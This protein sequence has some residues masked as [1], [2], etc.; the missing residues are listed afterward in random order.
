MKIAYF[1]CFSGISGNM[2]LGALIDA[3]LNLNEL[4]KQLK[5]LRLT[6]YR[7]QLKKTKKNGISAAY[8]DV[9]GGKDQPHRNLDDIKRII[10]GSKLSKE[11]KKRSVGIFTRLA[12]A[13]AKVHGTNTDNIHF[14]EVG[15]IDAIIDIVGCA[16]ALEMMGIREV[17]SS[18]LPLSRGFVKTSHGKLPVPAPATIELL[19]GIPVYDTGIKGELVTPTGAAVITSIASSFGLLPAMDIGAVGYGAGK[20][21]YGHPNVLRVMIG[22][23]ARQPGKETVFLIETNIDDMNPQFYDH[24]IERLL[25]AKALDVWLENIQMK[26]NRPGIKLSVLLNKKDLDPISRIILSETT[27]L[28]FRIREVARMTVERKFKTIKTK[29]GNIRVKVSS[30]KDFPKKTSPEYEDCKKA[31]KKF[32]VPLKEV[33][34]IALT[35][36]PSHSHL[37]LK[38]ADRMSGVR[39]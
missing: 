16:V 33:F 22:E 12:K 32:N 1:D 5:S 37:P 38:R 7:L 8:F 13:E 30:F 6:G 24:V 27:T 20:Y 15:A 21:D 28:G 18:P 29:Y 3:G 11:V 14:H 23:K 26:K 34:K 4:E 19:K 25:K 9:N 10:N 36:A 39:V 17:Y 31:A 35:P 2:I